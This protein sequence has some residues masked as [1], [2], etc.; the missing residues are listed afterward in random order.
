MGINIPKI[1]V[2]SGG[3]LGFAAAVVGG[4]VKHLRKRS[5]DV[6]SS[7]EL[8]LCAHCLL[9]VTCKALSS[10]AVVVSVLAC[11]YDLLVAPE[12]FGR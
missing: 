10:L 5:R 2:R 3:T 11:Q 1:D 7:A 12:C 6:S 8:D 9:F 4:G